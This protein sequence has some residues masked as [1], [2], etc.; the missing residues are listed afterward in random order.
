MY[1]SVGQD[2]YLAVLKMC[3][4]ANRQTNYVF[5]VQ[6]AD[7]LSA[8]SLAVIRATDHGV[9]V[10]CEWDSET[11]CNE[12]LLNDD[13]PKDS[14]SDKESDRSPDGS[15]SGET[16]VPHT[17]LFKCIGAVRDSRS[18]ETLRLC[19]ELMAGR[20]TVTIRMKH[21]PTNVKDARAI[22]FECEVDDKWRRIGYVHG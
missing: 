16:D 20:W 7:M 1:V 5:T 22:A 19:R 2:L 13:E 18:Q 17:V 10:V 21:E 15:D 6:V 9:L 3:G 4:I 14:D 11:T 8:T 12:P